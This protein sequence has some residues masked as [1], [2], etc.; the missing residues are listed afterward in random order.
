[1]QQKVRKFFRAGLSFAF[2]LGVFLVLFAVTKTPVAHATVGINQQINFQ[3]RLY[4]AAGAVVPDGAYNI[5]FKIYQD[6]DGLTAGNT[7]GTPAGSLK[8][9]ESYLNTSTQGVSVVNGFMSVQL[10]SITPFGTNVDW[11]QNTL[12]LSMNIGTTNGTC[13]PFTSCTPDGEMVPMKRLSAT[14]YALNAGQLGGLSAAGFIQ[15]TTTLQTANVAVQSSGTT[16]I[17][18]L[19]QG[20][21]LQTADIFQVKANGL[22][23]PL[24]AVSASGSLSVQPKTDSTGAFSVKTSLGNNMFTVDTLN[25]RVGIGLGGS[26]Q[27][28]VTGTGVQIQGALRLSG[29]GVLANDTDTFVTPVGSSVATKINIPLYDPGNFGQ[30]LALGLPST[31]SGSSRAISLLDARTAAHQPTLAVFS[32]DENNVFG[33]SWDGSNSVGYV[34]NTANDIALQGG[35]INTLL[36]RNISGVANVGIGNSAS[37]G[38]ALDV[39]GD[40]NSSTQ[41][42]VGGAVALTSSALSFSGATTASVR[43]A[44]G[45]ILALQGG[46]ATVGNANGGNMTLTGGTGIGTGVAGL[47]VFST[48][49]FSTTANDPNCYTGGALVTASCTIAVNSVNNSAAILAGFSNTGQSA[50]LPGPT[51]LTAGRVVYVTAANGSQDFTLIVNGGGTGNSIAMRQNTTATMIWNGAAWT[52]AGASSSTTL[53]SAY[54]NTLQSAGGAELIVSKT[55]T[56]NGISIRDSSINPVNGTLL[57]VQTTSAANLISVNGNVTEY[58]S[59]AGA[60]VNGGTQTTF[61]ANTWSTIGSATVSRYNT[62][63]A[64]INTGQASVSTVTTATANDGLKNTLTT[65][66]NANTNYNVSFTSRLSSGTFT[67]MNVYYSVDGTAASVPCAITATSTT[68]VWKKINCTFTAPAS[69]I[70]SANAILIRQTTG[71]ARTFY[72]DNL[73]VTI[74]ADFNYATD[75]GVDDPVNFATNWVAVAGSTVSR[76][77]SAGNNASDSAQVVTNGTTGMGVANKLSVNPL[78]NTLY[79]ITVYSASTTAGFNNFTVRY[80]RDGGTSFTTCA[81]YN[82][83]TISSSINSFTQVTCYITTDGTA[84][85]NPYVYFT[86]TDT[87]ARTFYVDTFAMNLSTASTPNVQIGGGVNGGPT[88]LL[89]LDRGASAPIASNNDALLGSMYYDTTLGKLQC[90]ESGGWG[91]CGSSPDNVITISPEYTNA[92][93]HGTG[94]G[95]MVSDICSGTLDINDGTNGQPTICGNNETYN[96]YKWTSPQLTTQTYSIYVTYQLP[97]SFKSFASGQTSIK[98]R[99]DSTNSTVNYQVYKSD[100]ST[101]LTACGSPVAVSTGSVSSWQVGIASGAADPSTCGFVPGNSIVFKVNAVASSN[102][103]A[104]IGNLNF[105]FSNR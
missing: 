8:W 77:T 78:T 48:P 62:A 63:G 25:N 5:Q 59:D 26:T 104:Y 52:A 13:T 101:G 37:S 56:T 84:P 6:G 21:A 28:G 92:V 79:R 68:S 98:G 89:T 85:T 1:M 39:T 102:A 22:T 27:P 82:T 51:I 90:Y 32:P 24:L 58:V 43:A 72:I 54:D 29:S 15:N 86:Q 97:G 53:Q 66:L 61:P 38:Y 74:A 10:G 40:I 87:V 95:T 88:T 49:T 55:A 75:G 12:W 80:T 44:S 67:D 16:S 45:Q 17:A 70:T 2:L 20:A 46:N 41:Y 93:L 42:R 33:F 31:A 50:S 100:A 18:A 57:S 4:N 60:E 96:F 64:Y 65:T 69:G 34:K 23:T 103:N 9:T 71:V 73:S 94:I 19:I 7:T 105:I 91:A 99:T 83:Q 11:N 3:G 36:A 30:I 76:A 35:G 14:P 81:D 47:V